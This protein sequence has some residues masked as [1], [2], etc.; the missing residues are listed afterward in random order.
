MPN[1]YNVRD[2]TKLYQATLG[3]QPL[4]QQQL[5]HYGLQQQPN[6]QDINRMTQSIIGG[7]RKEPIG[8]ITSPVPIS[9]GDKSVPDH[10]QPMWTP[11]N[12]QPFQPT[13]QQPEPMSLDE[14]M[15]VINRRL[16]LKTDPKISSVERQIEEERLAGIQ[17]MGDVRQAYDEGVSDLARQGRVGQQQLAGIMQ[18]RGIYDAGMGAD[19]STRLMSGFKGAGL[20]LAQEQARQLSD[21]AEYINLR[22]RHGHE[23]IQ[24]IMGQRADMAADMLAEMHLQQQDRMDRLAQMEFE[25]YLAQEAHDMEVWR[26]IVDAYMWGEQFDQQAANQAWQ[27]YMGERQM[28]LSEEQAAWDRIKWMN[29][30]EAMQEL[31]RL[32]YNNEIEQQTFNNLMS[33]LQLEQQ[34]AAYRAMYG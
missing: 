4:S 31:E 17:Q 30:F 3:H 19:L 24:E 21:I 33:I 20:E 23:Q 1:Q 2:L 5:E 26:S 11:A 22:T 34:S 15:E 18:D 28:Q 7:Q 9:P 25:R 10:E 13:I 8:H 14:Q 16:D 29:E 12:R 6:V 32:R 27:Q